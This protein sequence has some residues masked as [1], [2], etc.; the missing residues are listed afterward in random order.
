[1]RRVLMLERVWVHVESQEGKFEILISNP[2]YQIV[3]C[4]LIFRISDLRSGIVRFQILR[5]TSLS[6]DVNL[7]SS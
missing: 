2:K 6:T 4:N 7:T 3:Q 5:W 1:M